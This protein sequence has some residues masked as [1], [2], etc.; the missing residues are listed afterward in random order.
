[1]LLKS[2][3][4]FLFFLV[5][6]TLFFLVK[7]CVLLDFRLVFLCLLTL[8]LFCLVQFL[9]RLLKIRISSFMRGLLFLF[10]FCAEVLGE[11]FTFYMTFPYWDNILHFVFG[12]I[13][14]CFG[15]SI[16]KFFLKRE[17][18]RDNFG[19]ILVFFALCFSMTIGVVWEFFEFGMDKY[20]GYDMQ[21]DTFIKKINSANI[22][23]SFNDIVFST[24]DILYTEIYTNEGMIRL[25]K[26]Y[27]DIGLIDTMEDLKMN[28]LGALFMLVFGVIR[29][30]YF[31]EFFLIRESQ[32]K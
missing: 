25:D 14:A 19:F 28:G 17:K 16:M 3:K 5:L 31:D 22:G 2:E 6:F 10:I 9:E 21:K 15:F 27:L 32:K 11:G 8:V 4:Y 26:G 30:S 12:F 18:I 7:G 29:K 24:D 1:M 23:E 20:F 13:S